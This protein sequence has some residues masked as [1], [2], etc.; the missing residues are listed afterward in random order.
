MKKDMIQLT[1][2]MHAMTMTAITS[3]AILSIYLTSVVILTLK[4]KINAVAKN[5]YSADY[6]KYRHGIKTHC[7]E[8]EAAKYHEQHHCS[9]CVA[10]KIKPMRT[11]VA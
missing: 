11:K 2:S 4:S 6:Y 8:K 9:S 10:A 7:H 3:P 5:P 1:I